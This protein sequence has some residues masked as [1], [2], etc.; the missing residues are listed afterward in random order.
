MEDLKTFQEVLRSKREE[1]DYFIDY[2]SKK[3]IKKIDYHI[4]GVGEEA[5][6][7]SEKSK[8]FIQGSK[9]YRYQGKV[10]GSEKRAE[11]FTKEEIFNKL[12]EIHNDKLV[13]K[14]SSSW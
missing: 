5:F 8:Y 14:L 1:Y 2:Y 9:A 7:S 6:S 10:E 12:L 3:S 11:F 13:D 4:Q